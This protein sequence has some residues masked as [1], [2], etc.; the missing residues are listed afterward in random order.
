MTRFT[1]AHYKLRKR[2]PVVRPAQTAVLARPPVKP[3]QKPVVAAPPSPPPPPPPQVRRRALCIGINY[4]GTSLQL[5]GCIND[6]QNIANALLASAAF[7]HSDIVLMN[8][9]LSGAAYPTLANIW[10]QLDAL[11]Q[12]AAQWPSSVRVDLFVSYSGHGTRR[13]DLSGEEKDYYDE[14]ILPVNFRSAGYIRDDD[15]RQR[16]IALLPSNVTLVLLTDA[17]NSGSIADS[18]FT[19]NLATPRVVTTSEQYPETTCTCISLSASQDA[20]LAVDAWLPD[21]VTGVG[22]VQGALSSAF[23]RFFNR[24]TPILK[25]AEAMKQWVLAQK[26]TQVTQLSSSRLLSDSACFFP[27]V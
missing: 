13:I 21:P 25:L 16:F 8:D 3:E 1:L 14:A 20:Q 22:E 15:L 24:T 12:W 10:G 23:C 17:C 2:P 26:F 27:A 11:R 18:R 5:Q 4:R 7:S 9:N 19:Y 6:Q